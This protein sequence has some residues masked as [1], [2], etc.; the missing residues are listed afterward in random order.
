MNCYDQAVCHSLAEFEEDIKKFLYLRK[1]ILR[2]KRD[3]DLKE[4]LILNH[5][6]I[7][8][9]I[10]GLETT[11]MLFFKIDPECWDV[12]I[13]FLVYLQ[14]MPNEIPEYGI[15]VSNFSLDQTILNTLRTL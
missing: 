13:T 3:G 6:I 5:I 15:D 9:N 1:L 12:L 8:Y 2:Y 7:L 11:K 10:F 4:R 14:R